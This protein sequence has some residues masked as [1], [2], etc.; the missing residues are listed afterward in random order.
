[1]KFRAKILPLLACAALLSPVAAQAG[2]FYIQ[3][4]SARGQGLAYAG[5]AADA[6]DASVLFYNP[7]GITQL[8]ETTATFG[9]GM[10]APSASFKNTGSTAGLNAGAQAAYTGNTG[11]EPFTAGFV[12]SFYASMPVK[13][14]I[15]IG[16]GVSAPF[17]L[18]N[19]YD[20]GWF[21]RYDSIKSVLTTNDISPVIA[22]KVN[23]HVSIAG[24]PDFQY[25]TADLQ[26]ALPCPT[27][28]AGCGAAFSP[29]SD[30]LLRA[31]GQQ[32]EHGL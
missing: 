7:A 17:G 12:P 20:V 1:M 8:D 32:L 24:G 13:D 3:E 6:A 2:G 5:S 30:G 27:A 4:Q 21:G 11:G 18:A 25:A 10:V 22:Y 9:L 26:S 19:K 15:W 29:T 14:N 28:G 23:D 16:L 31:D